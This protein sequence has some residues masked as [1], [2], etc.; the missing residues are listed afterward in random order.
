MLNM[1]SNN[2]HTIE[3]YSPLDEIWSNRFPEYEVN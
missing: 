2:N 1:V 3:Y